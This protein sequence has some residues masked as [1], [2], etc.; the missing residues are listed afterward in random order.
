M[1]EQIE[2]IET[3]IQAAAS[4]SRRPE[5]SSVALHLSQAALNCANALMCV[6]TLR[7]G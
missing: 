7:N 4:M 1:E 6:Q 2:H 3:L 5:Q